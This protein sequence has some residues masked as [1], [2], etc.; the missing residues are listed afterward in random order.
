MAKIGLRMLSL[1]K[2]TKM[3]Q[4]GSPPHPLAKDLPLIFL[5]EIPNMPDHGVFIGHKTG[6]AYVGY[7]IAD[8]EELGP[9]EI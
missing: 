7:H 4:S 6:R 2:L 5:G 1:V 8:F 3:A 9:G